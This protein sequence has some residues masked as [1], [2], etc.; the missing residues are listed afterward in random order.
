MEDRSIAKIETHTSIQQPPIEQHKT[1]RLRAIYALNLVVLLSIS[2][3]R[4]IAACLQ[5]RPIDRRNRY[6]DRISMQNPT[7]PMSI[8]IGER[9]CF[10]Y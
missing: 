3:N 8:E 10:K 9:I 1:T 7:A 4:S 6:V 2:L 5:T